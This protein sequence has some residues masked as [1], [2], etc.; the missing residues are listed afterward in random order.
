MLAWVAHVGLYVATLITIVAG[1]FLAGALQP[2]VD[3]KLLGCISIPTQAVFQ[4]KALRD[5]LALMHEAAA[6]ALM[7]MVVLH[8]IAALW[9]H[10]IQRDSVLRRMWLREARTDRGRASAA[11]C[12]PAGHLS[13]LSWTALT[14]GAFLL[15]SRRPSTDLRTG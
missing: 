3:V 9:H 10:F 11:E 4:D 12:A 2:A 6:D 14:E 8:V 15:R 1:W 13:W 5:L 7:V